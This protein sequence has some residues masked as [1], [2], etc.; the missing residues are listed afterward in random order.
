MGLTVKRRGKM[1]YYKA[2][3]YKVTD[4]GQEDFLGNVIVE[5]HQALP[6]IGEEKITDAVSEF[7][8]AVLTKDENEALSGQRPEYITKAG[9]DIGIFKSDINNQNIATIDQVM[10]YHELYP[11]TP[12]SEEQSNLNSGLNTKLGQK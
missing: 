5:K 7:S 6:I 4:K 2:K 12:V 9:F 10:E 11:I 3:A 8:Y 1:K